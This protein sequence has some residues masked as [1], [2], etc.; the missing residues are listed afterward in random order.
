MSHGTARHASEQIDGWNGSQPHSGAPNRK[1]RRRR[2]DLRNSA[3][4]SETQVMAGPNAL[5]PNG[6]RLMQLLYAFFRTNGTWPSVEA[7]QRELDR[8]D[9]PFDAYAASQ[10]VPER[11][12]SREWAAGGAMRLTLRGVLECDGGDDDGANFMHALR[13]AAARRK[14]PDQVA[15]IECMDFA[16]SNMS[17]TACQRLVDLLDREQHVVSGG[18]GHG[19]PWAR[20]VSTDMRHFLKVTTLDEYFA[21]KDRLAAEREQGKTSLGG[22][23]GGFGPNEIGL[24]S[25]TDRSAIPLEQPTQSIVAARMVELDDLATALLQRLD[26]GEALTNVLPTAYRLFADAGDGEHAEW[27][28]L[29]VEGLKPG[30]RSRSELTDAE[31]KGVFDFLRLRRSQSKGTDDEPVAVGHPMVQLEHLVEISKNRPDELAVAIHHDARA[32]IERVRLELTAAVAALRRRV[33]EERFALQLFG[34][35]A[36]SIFEAGGEILLPL[37]QAVATLREGNGA[38]AALQGRSALIAIGDRLLVDTHQDRI[39]PITGRTYRVSSGEKNRLRAVLDDLWARSSP[40]RQVVLADAYGQVDRAYE[41]G[42]RAK[43]P[44]GL[45]HAECQEALALTFQIVRAVALAAGFPLR[46]G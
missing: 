2:V 33:R 18:T 30:L 4:V 43:R 10:E 35:D 36:L 34:S 44:A 13:L 21:I 28:R 42:S 26:S 7:I 27:L 14:G 8:A 41:L 5:S 24:R 1:R 20:D 9:D 22:F 38:G 17:Q 19:H 23:P 6:R 3:A 45:T 12:A 46:Q 16:D 31:S 15:K 32:L 39:S 11:Y 29:E 37:R 25:L 40:D